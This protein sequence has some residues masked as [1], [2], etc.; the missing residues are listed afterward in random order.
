MQVAISLP[1]QRSVLL[2]NGDLALSIIL[3]PYPPFVVSTAFL[4]ALLLFE[5]SNSIRSKCVTFTE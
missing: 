2:I 3:F 4:M 1:C 5:F